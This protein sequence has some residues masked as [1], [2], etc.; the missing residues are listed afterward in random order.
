VTRGAHAD[1]SC[2]EVW[3]RCLSP[4]LLPPLPPRDIE[5]WWSWSSYRSCGVQRWHLAGCHL[6]ERDRRSPRYL[7]PRVRSVR[8]QTSADSPPGNSAHSPHTVMLFLVHHSSRVDV[9]G[10]QAARGLPPDRR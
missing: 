3:A 4:A 1:T 5:P 9:P 6:L 10:Q 2:P 8:F 7:T